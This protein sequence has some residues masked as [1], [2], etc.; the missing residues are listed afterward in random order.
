MRE[1]IKISTNDTL[2]SNM[3]IDIPG[4]TASN[5]PTAAE[6]SLR[7]TWLQQICDGDFTPISMLLDDV[8]QDLL[9]WERNVVNND[10]GTLTVTYEKNGLEV[11]MTVRAPSDCAVLEWQTRLVNHGE[12]ETPILSEINLL[13]M[14][15]PAKGSTLTW[16]NGANASEYDFELQTEELEHGKKRKLSCDGGRSSS[17]VMPYW[18]LDC[19]TYTY[20]GAIGWTG[21]W[22][23]IFEQGADSVQVY[24]GMTHG[25]Y[26]MLPGEVLDLPSMALIPSEDENGYNK[27]RRWIQLYHTPQYNGKLALGPIS[28]GMWGAISEDVHLDTINDLAKADIGYEAY[29]I[30]AG[31]YGKEDAELSASAYD[32]VWFN[33][34]GTWS[35]LPSLYPNGLK[36]I[37]TAAEENGLRFLLWFEP[38]RANVRS[39]LVQEHPEWFLDART[40]KENMLFNFADDEAR[41]YM[42]DFICE[43]IQEY[44]VKIY[45]QD[46]NISPLEYW[47]YNDE[48]D[49]RGIT[50]IKYINGLYQ[51]WRDLLTRNPGLVIDDCAGGGRRLDFAAISLA[52]VMSKSDYQCFESIATAEGCQTQMYGLNHWIGP[53]GIFAMR[54]LQAYEVR[55]NYGFSLQMQLD[56]G[57]VGMQEDVIAEMKRCRPYFYGDYYPLLRN[58]E[59]EPGWTVLQFDRGDLGEGVV[60]AFCAGDDME[61]IANLKG[62]DANSNYILECVDTNEQITITGADMMSG[63]PIQVSSPK[64]SRLYFYTKS[65]SEANNK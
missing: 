63:I 7:D 56:M 45:R 61:A 18:H 11:Q 6:L 40:D 32:N 55:S 12:G 31:W 27:L 37:G 17:G 2:L 65:A 54:R 64:Q 13:D 36:S 44:G 47:V 23:A 58:A 52:T 53:T 5:T 30:D 62:L 42:T 20:L 33:N 26:Y 15:F 25:N 29:W 46:F 57:P 3:L 4:P 49:R 28:Q 1:S 48:P 16:S 14:S 41:A 50:E 22:Q 21:Q 39:Q 9:T 60:F 10:D 19:G 51:F 34:V 8:P 59:S 35:P 38:E 24:S 43:K